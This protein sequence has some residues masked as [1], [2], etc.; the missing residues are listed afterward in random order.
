MSVTSRPCVLEVKLLTGCHIAFVSTHGDSDICL[1]VA[2]T[3]S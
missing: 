2:K 3:N 1:N